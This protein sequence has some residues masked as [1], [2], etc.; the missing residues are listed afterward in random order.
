MKPRQPQA[1]L[2]RNL[3]PMA[4]HKDT[5]HIYIYTIITAYKKKG[6]HL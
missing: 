5:S 1:N 2:F 6:Y 4:V 3:D